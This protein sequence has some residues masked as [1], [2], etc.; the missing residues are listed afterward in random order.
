MNDTI[1]RF[2]LAALLFL[3]HSAYSDAQTNTYDAAG[4]LIRSA[5]ANGRG[6]SYSYDDSDNL[7]SATAINVPLPPGSVTVTRSSPTEARIT[8]QAGGSS[9][10]SYVVI[11]R[12]RNGGQWEQIASVSGSTFQYI[13]PT[14]DPTLD[15][16]YRIATA[17]NN[18]TSAYS[19][20]IAASSN[21]A[22]AVRVD[23]RGA[24]SISTLAQSVSIRTGYANLDIDSGSTPYG[25]AVF[26]Y[27]QGGAVVSEAA[28]PSSPPTLQNRI[29]IDYRQNVTSAAG[30]FQGTVSF[31]TGFAVANP[32]LRAAQLMLTLRRQ[33]G[34]AIATGT[35]TL[36][37]GQHF[38][39]FIDELP[40][41]APGF[42][43]PADFATTTSFGALDIES[44]VPVSVMALR[45]ATNQRGENLFTS[46]PVADLAAAQ[47]STPAYFPQFADGGGY[48]TSFIL[49]NTSNSAEAGT[50]EL[51]DNSGAPISV[52]P[53]GLSSGSSFSYTIPAGGFVVFETDG[54]STAVRIG[55]V[56]W[57][58]A[59]GNTSPVGSG[60]FRFAQGGVVVSESGIPSATP[61]TR[62][63][64]Y[65]DKTAGRDTGVAIASPTA[66]GS[67]LTVRAYQLDGA[68]AVG[69]ATSITLPSAGH[70]AKLA[71]E[72]V[73]SLAAGFSGVL[74]ISSSTP[75]VALT[76]RLFTNAR[77]ET[78]LTTFP[79]ADQ[80]RA[81]PFPVVFP[82]VAD[83]GGFETEFILLGPVSAARTVV[84]FY[85][86]LG[87][88]LPVG[89]LP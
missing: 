54:G 29:F 15:Y 60:I 1:Y 12:P 65:I 52:K 40:A 6:I 16:L 37:A 58:P 35:A 53:I 76:L 89:K 64:I 26:R 48:N 36:A 86:G 57:V 4:R 78:L 68:S 39:R 30:Q 63:R 81:A 73:P 79:V 62:A 69:S 17:N 43:F 74:D 66:A 80:T 2:T 88:P 7:L 56:R 83:G 82:Q 51:R 50:L 27:T 19:D 13:D 61:T 21:S 85:D 24:R 9:G 33:D 28:V 41:I 47:S 38:A 70:D 87:M 77:G 46:T 25:T 11:R 49:L 84:R 8:W 18:E 10:T 22:V 20:E 75:F 5:Y 23:S 3:S 34:V 31:N 32:D 44:T 71:G 67:T 14:L 55:W 59:A 42:V 45:M 72:L